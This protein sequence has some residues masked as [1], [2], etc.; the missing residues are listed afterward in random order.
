[1]TNNTFETKQS[2]ITSIIKA[3]VAKFEVAAI[4]QKTNRV[5]VT[6]LKFGEGKKTSSRWSN[7]EEIEFISEEIALDPISYLGMA[8]SAVGMSVRVSLSGE[9]YKNERLIHVAATQSW[10]M[11]TGGTNGTRHDF[12]WHVGTEKL[13]TREEVQSAIV[14]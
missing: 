1:M 5:A 10:S 2:D 9:V 12:F 7:S 3:I 4:C 13:M 6:E 11:R 14:L 8:F